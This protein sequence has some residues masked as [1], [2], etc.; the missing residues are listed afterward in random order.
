[1]KPASFQPGCLLIGEA[2]TIVRL[3]DCDKLARVILIGAGRT[4]YTLSEQQNQ[5]RNGIVKVIRSVFCFFFKEN[6]A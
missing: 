3:I 6:Y 5:I 1:M 2:H 4:K